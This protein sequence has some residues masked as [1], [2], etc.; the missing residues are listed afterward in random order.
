MIV[1]AGYFVN[2]ENHNYKNRRSQNNP[3]LTDSLK[4]SYIRVDEFVSDDFYPFQNCSALVWSN[5]GMISQNFTDSFLV[6]RW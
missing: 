4:F 3:R 6:R 5:F 1:G 2:S